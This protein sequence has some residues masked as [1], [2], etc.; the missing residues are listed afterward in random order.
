MWFGVGSRWLVAGTAAIGLSLLHT[1]TPS[2]QE[3][4]S[5]PSAYRAL[6]AT[7][8][9]GD[10]AGAVRA[11]AAFPPNDLLEHAESYREDAA[12]SSPASELD[13]LAAA[14]LHLDIAG[15]AGTAPVQNEKT[16]RLLLDRVDWV[17]RDAWVR[18][19][20]LGLMGLHAT[21]GRLA[22]AARVIQFL[23]ARYGNDPVVVLNRARYA[24][25]VGWALHDDRF[26][27][28]ARSD[29]NLL[30]RET[31]S[32][33][34]SLDLTEMRLHLAHLILRGGYPQETLTRLESVG[35]N[36]N[37]LHRFVALLIKGEALLWL[38]QTAAAEEAFAGAQALRA[39]SGVG[40][41][42]LV[43]TREMLGNSDDASAAAR[44]F[45]FQTKGEDPWWNFMAGGLSA[46]RRHLDPLRRLVSERD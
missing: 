5:G 8:R 12:A 13:L 19:S 4:H 2:A 16:A 32:R 37:A 34:A 3:Q 44:R 11:G 10:F 27:E 18:S 1:G 6:V 28:Q 21:A 14:L 43:A 31:V 35:D 22:D 39:G 20:H 41:A 40:A 7:Y 26:F 45:L 17:R 9:N 29:Y 15:V 42:A 36:L 23:S 30:L 24:E 46:E 25:V 33:R 38:G